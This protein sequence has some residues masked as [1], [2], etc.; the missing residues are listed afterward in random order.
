MLPGAFG[1]MA[2]VADSL[3]EATEAQL[4]MEAKK[5]RKSSRYSLEVVPLVGDLQREKIAMW[6]KAAYG[7][8]NFS[9]YTVI[10]IQAYFLNVF[11]LEVADLGTFWAGN[12]LLV[13][14][15]FDGLTDPLVGGLSDSINTRWGRRK[16]W[17][18][19]AS[20]PSGVFWILQW[21]SPGFTSD[22]TVWSVVYFTIILM[23]FGLM[24]T[25]ISVPYN[26]M[27]PDVAVDYD[28]RTAVVLFQ[29]VFGLSAVIVFSY[30]QAVVIEAF[31]EKDDPTQVDSQKG[32]LV[33]S[34][35]T[36]FAVV[37]P[38][39]ISIA[40]VKELPVPPK[41]G[42]VETS[43]VKIVLNWCKSFFKSL[44]R[45]LIFKEFALI[46][47]V[48]VLCMVA[49]Y[50]FVNNFVL[51]IKYVLQAEE[52]TSYLLLTVQAT[53]TLSIFFWA[54][55]SRRIGKRLTFFVGSTFWIGGSVIIFFIN[56][57]DLRV[58]YVV[59]VFRA[60]GSG[61]GYLIP[62]AILPDVIEL[63]RLKNNE[64][65]E[66]ILYSLMILIQKTGV[67]I[68]VTASN[69]ILGLTGY[70]PPTRGNGGV[71]VVQPEAVLLSFR[72]L[73]TVVPIVCVL[74]ALIAIYFINVTKETLDELEA[75]MGDHDVSF[76]PIAPRTN[77]I[78]DERK[79]LKD[80][81]Y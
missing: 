66:G 2:G 40:F 1:D 38:M 43:K 53:C 77:N 10:G 81:L 79:A 16:P 32:Y 33:A 12:I 15:I 60:I 57:N 64:K 59:A 30:F 35:V 73:M 52:Q 17:I 58:F 39:L 71:L 21:Y 49:V 3:D 63:D 62:L 76:R 51:Y 6:R 67:G 29:E 65:R 5:R 54:F 41:E 78:D 22:S 11:L 14:Q 61:V 45:S 37:I 31:P 50:L 20:I 47:L 25:F 48:F 36:V 72:I 27:V 9:R 4:N 8:G 74:L 55:L 13:K 56:E 69:Y 7:F 42:S 75:N 80:D 26:A 24:N 18:L 70:I 68:A 23:S 28:D 19:L 34:F 44:Y 46:V